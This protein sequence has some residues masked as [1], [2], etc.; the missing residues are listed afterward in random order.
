MSQQMTPEKK[1]DIEFFNTLIDTDLMSIKEGYEP[2]AS[3]RSNL[4]LPAQD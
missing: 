3:T 2:S 4:G 1:F